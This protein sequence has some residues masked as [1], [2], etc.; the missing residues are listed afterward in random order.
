[1]L[2]PCAGPAPIPSRDAYSVPEVA[3]LWLIDREHLKTCRDRQAALS[4]AVT[5][6]DSIQGQEKTP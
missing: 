3:R 5:A 2:R 6:R 1:M 4:A